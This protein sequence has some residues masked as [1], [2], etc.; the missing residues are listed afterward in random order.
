MVLALGTRLGPFGTLPQYGLDYWPK[1][2]KIIQVDADAKMLGLVQ[3]DR[4]GHLR[5]RQGCGAGAPRAPRRPRRWP[6]TPTSPSGSPRSQAEKAAWEA[7]LDGWTHETDRLVARRRRAAPAPCTRGKCCASW[8]ARCRAAAMVST[9]IGN[10]CS[11]AN[12]LSALRA[13]ALDVRR[14]ELRQLRLRVPDHHRR[15]GRRARPSGDC[16]R[17]RRRLGH[18]LRRAADLRARATFR[19]P[20]SYSTTA[21][22]ARRRRITSTSTASR[23]VGVNLDRATVVGRGRHGDGRARAGGSTGSPTS[24]RRCATPS[25][26][27]REG[28]TTV[29]EM[30]VT[31]E[32]GDP[33]RRDALAAADAT[34]RQ[35]QVHGGEALNRRRLPRGAAR[36]ACL[37]L[38]AS[39]VVAE[40]AGAHG[41]EGLPEPADSLRRAL[42]A[43]RRHRHRRP[44]PRRPARR[45]AGATDHRRQPRRRRRQPR[46][47]HRGQVRARRLHDPVYALLAIRSTPSS[48]TSCRSTS[49][50]TSRR[51]AWRR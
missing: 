48:T 36:V 23:F 7:E 3:A 34:S 45:G 46:H 44:Y 33:F 4:G 27:Q 19:S 12:S 20:R 13:A 42:S 2:A 43:R 18:E 37:L 24:G 8:S 47:R 51:S 26:A 49:R 1:N 11:V 15:Q 5:R 29:L 14:D 40:P 30:M 22:G 41:R 28:K 17:R 38:L 35:V 21:N 50:G 10:I 39:L 6:A 9:D 16:L 32:L 25:Q 31:R